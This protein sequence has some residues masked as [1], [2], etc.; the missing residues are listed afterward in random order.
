L[1]A[2]RDSCITCGD[3]AV[4]A[5]VVEVNGSTAVVEVEGQRE[6]IGVE[7]VAPVAPGERVLCH[8][9]I[10]LTKLEDEA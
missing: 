8:A 2:D 6:R 1:T 4:A 3:V 5:V 10:A 7:L 9:G